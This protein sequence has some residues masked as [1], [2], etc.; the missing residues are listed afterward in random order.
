MKKFW[1]KNR[2]PPETEQEILAGKPSAFWYRVYASVIF[3]TI[4]AIAALWLFSRYFS[5]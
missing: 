4:L 1:E 2:L 5:K 3:T